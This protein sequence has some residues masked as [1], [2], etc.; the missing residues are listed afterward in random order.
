MK[1]SNIIDSHVHITPP[2]IKNNMKKYR[3]KES[4]FDLL[5]G[6]EVNRNVTGEE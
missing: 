5:S 4:Y 3:K 6:S 2:E 1:L